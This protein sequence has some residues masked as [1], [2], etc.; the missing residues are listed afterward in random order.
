MA[1]LILGMAGLA[2]ADPLPESAFDWRRPNESGT[3]IEV[4]AGWMRVDPDG[5]TYRANYLRFAPQV[6]VHHWFYVGAAF[7][8]GKIYSAYGQM[9]GMIPTE[10]S[11]DF[12]GLTCHAPM[13]A[14]SYDQTTGTIVEP[15]VFFGARDLV[16][17]VS[18]GFEV[19]PTV[20]WTSSAVS[21]LNQTFTTAEKTVELHGRVDVWATPHFSAGV[22]VGTEYDRFHDLQV[23]LQIGFHMEPY[24][25]MT[26]N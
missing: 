24:D 22:M 6:S 5:M 20:R 19:A 7:E 1:G 4:G 2:S 26:R 14:D 10:C 12:G 15:Q 9:N 25:L 16:G 17:I 18:G 13:G 8:V 23:G 3:Y 21:W 11:K